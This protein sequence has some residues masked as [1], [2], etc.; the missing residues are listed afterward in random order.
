MTFTS[1]ED[2]L[3][4]FAATEEADR[5]AKFAQGDALLLAS[6]P[7]ALAAL[8]FTRR[9]QLF[10]AVGSATGLSR[11]ALLYRAQ[12]CEVFGPEQRST[13][14]SWDV[15]RAASGMTDPAYWL[16]RAFD[17]HLSAE[18]L[19]AV[20]KQAAGKDAETVEITWPLRNQDAALFAARQNEQGW[21]ITFRLPGD[22]DVGALALGA[23]GQ[24]SYSVA[25][26]HVRAQEAA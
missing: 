4:V 21:F 10:A 6:E 23:H 14:V 8:G 12:V 16:A 26:A 15:Y 20:Y 2:V 18:K 25:V 19:R 7:D 24:L 5:L 11:R 22:A 17:D 1:L 9:G 3:S 13:P